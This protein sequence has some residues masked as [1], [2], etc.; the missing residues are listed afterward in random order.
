MKLHDYQQAA[1]DAS[2]DP[3]TVE[4]AKIPNNA[5]EGTVNLGDASLSVWE[6]PELSPIRSE[7]RESFR[8]E[9][10]MPM[11]E[12]LERIGWDMRPDDNVE[13]IIRD[14]YFCG[15]YR[16]IYCRLELCGRS[17]KLEMWQ[18]S[19]V[20]N[21]N[22]G[23]YDFDK[24]A[25][26]SF[27]QRLRME[28]TRIRMVNFLCDIRMANLLCD[29]FPR[30]K[31]NKK[32]GALAGP[33]LTAWEEIKT[34]IKGCWHYKP[35]ID[36]RG[37]E[38]L[39]SNNRSADGGT[40][41]HGTRVW[42]F[43]RKGRCCT[44]IT[45]YNINNMWWVVTGKRDRRNLASFDLYTRCPENPRTKRNEKTRRRKLESLLAGAVETMRYQDAEK[46]RRLLFGSHALFRVRSKKHDAYHRP[47]W[48]GYTGS[49]AR[50]GL[51]TADELSRCSA[52][53]DVI[54]PVGERPE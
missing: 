32:H 13:K 16:D 12:E 36:R 5:R 24:E 6:K 14:D 17:I 52:E 47:L 48:R 40:V 20:E 51:F 46:Y 9:V 22:G 41:R 35:E 44:G 19:N 1:I 21:P 50:A 3:Y 11:L 8:R 45:H 54:I 4:A 15:Q 33:P 39:Y 10:L 42:Y 34:D 31:L 49:T 28:R 2:Q 38:E 37:G 43:D 53:H 30:Y 25:R 18:E 29:R 26:M 27:I 7:W 23:R